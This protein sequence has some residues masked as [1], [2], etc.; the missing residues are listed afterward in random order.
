MSRQ[1]VSRSLSSI[2]V[3]RALGTSHFQ[4]CELPLTCWPMIFHIISDN[5]ERHVSHDHA[6]IEMERHFGNV[7]TNV[8][9]KWSQS[10]AHVSLLVHGMRVE[11][12]K[13]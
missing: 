13:T 3:P 8:A 1:R 7:Q 6:Q 12:L 2:H 11:R 4:W 9:V 10:R 5:F